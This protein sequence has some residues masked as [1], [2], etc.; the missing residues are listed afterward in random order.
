MGLKLDFIVKKIPLVG[1]RTK[2]IYQ[3]EAVSSLE[4]N[5]DYSRLFSAQYITP[6]VVFSSLKLQ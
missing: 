3:G 2:L 4:S 5:R 1:S 6:E